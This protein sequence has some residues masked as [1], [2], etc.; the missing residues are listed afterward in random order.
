MGA[1]P[2]INVAHYDD[3]RLRTRLSDYY[4]YYY[5][6]KIDA[7]DIIRKLH[8]VKAIDCLTCK[9]LLRWHTRCNFLHLSSLFGFPDLSCVVL[10]P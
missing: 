2:T 3:I 1:V 6:T 8:Y 4:Y 7:S 5:P 9:T 10:F